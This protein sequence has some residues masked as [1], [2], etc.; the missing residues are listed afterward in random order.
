MKRSLVLALGIWIGVSPLSQAADYNQK[1]YVPFRNDSLEHFGVGAGGTFLGTQVLQFWG[2]SLG[3][4]VTLSALASLG[5]TFY[6]EYGYDPNPGV[7]DLI[8]G[9]VGT[10]IGTLAAVTL[11]FDYGSGPQQKKKSNP[12]KQPL[13]VN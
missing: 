6:K 11:R 1:Y 13:P 10:L 4:A 3:P 12:S 2:L 7:N 9:T 5:A 8:A